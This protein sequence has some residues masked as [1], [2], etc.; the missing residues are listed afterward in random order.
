MS[1]QNHQIMLGQGTQGRL[2]LSIKTLQRHFAC[3]GSSG[4]GKTVASKV[5][6]EELA[7]QGIPIIAF[8]PQ[9]DIASLALIESKEELE[10]KGV[11]SSI[12]KDFEENV[13]V[14][15]WTPGSSKGLPICINPLQFDGIDE[16]SYE[17][18]TRTFSSIAKNISSLVGYDLD[19]DDGKSAEAVLAVLF[20]HC[21][22]ENIT[23]FDFNDVVEIL[24]DLPEA[25]SR[26]VAS[27]GTSQFLRDY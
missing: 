8:D 11:E 19:N 18:K 9:G 27:V 22:N 2:G 15:I 1:K 4:S 12:Q 20:E 26:V 25:V 7:R 24:G 6:I 16:L 3:F 17:D 13:E 10:K 5:L 14:V 21:Y 23:L